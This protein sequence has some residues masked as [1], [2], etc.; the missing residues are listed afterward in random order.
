[1]L[2]LKHKPSSLRFFRSAVDATTE[3]ENALFRGNKLSLV[4][5]AYSSDS[6]QEEIPVHIALQNTIFQGKGLTTTLTFKPLPSQ[7]PSLQVLEN[8]MELTN[9]G[10]FINDEKI[11]E[12]V[13]TTP[14][15]A[16]LLM[17]N[18]MFSN[19][20]DYDAELYLEDVNVSFMETKI[21]GGNY[22]QF[23]L[24]DVR[25]TSTGEFKQHIT[26]LFKDKEYD[27]ENIFSSLTVRNEVG[28]PVPKLDRRDTKKVIDLI[29][30]PN[31]TGLLLGSVMFAPRLGSAVATVYPM[32][33]NMQIAQSEDGYMFIADTGTVS[34]KE[35]DIKYSTVKKVAVDK[36]LLS[37]YVPD[38]VIRVSL[39]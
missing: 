21:L 12:P 9:A 26:V 25:E 8:I 38:G 31:L 13:F 34:V 7:I 4:G 2:V 14:F 15:K 23:V 27:A 19:I 37:L 24:E 29:M 28:A 39:G 1:M 33:S 17:S 22:Y 16:D 11:M 6:L 3:D 5:L 36:Y 10:S 20:Q 18:T 32:N 30:E 35:K